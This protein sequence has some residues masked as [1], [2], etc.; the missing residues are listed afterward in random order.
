MSGRIDIAVKPGSRV[1]SIEK[2]GD[3]YIVRTKARAIDGK[4]NEAVVRLLAEYFGV[5]KT[6]IKLVHG[7]ASRHKVFEIPLN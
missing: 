2:I 7:H 1:D 5:P 3:E 4:A 6:R